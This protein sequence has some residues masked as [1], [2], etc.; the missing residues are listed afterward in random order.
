MTAHFDF[1]NL[2]DIIVY[3]AKLIFGEDASLL[4]KRDC[5]ERTPLI[6]RWRR[7]GDGKLESRW[8]ME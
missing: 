5:G 1:R 6:M 4:A 3:P 2:R 7:G 8:E